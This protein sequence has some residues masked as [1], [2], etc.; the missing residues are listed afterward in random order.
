M[1]HFIHITIIFVNCTSKKLGGKI[2]TRH[3]PEIKDEIVK[4]KS[5]FIRTLRSP[6]SEETDWQTDSGPPSPPFLVR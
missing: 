4:V 2:E 5:N 6:S 1:V 3:D